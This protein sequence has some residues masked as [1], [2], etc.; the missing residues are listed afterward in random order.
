[1]VCSTFFSLALVCKRTLK[2]GP[3]TCIE[4]VSHA[5]A[6]RYYLIFPNSILPLLPRIHSLL[7]FRIFTFD[8]ALN[9]KN[10]FQAEQKLTYFR[11]AKCSKL[12]SKSNNSQLNIFYIFFENLPKPPR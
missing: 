5:W 4:Q 7:K 3:K 12:S 1:M 6:L 10:S 2:D 8:L 9:L 11:K